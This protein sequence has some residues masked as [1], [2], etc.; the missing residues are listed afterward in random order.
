MS[1]LLITGSRKASEKMILTAFK[2]VHRAQQNG[3]DIIVGDARGIDTHV[4]RECVNLGVIYDCFG[5]TPTP[6][7]P[8]CALTNYHYLEFQGTH[9]ERYLARDRH[10]ADLADYCLAIWDGS[11]GGTIYTYKYFKGLDKPCWLIDFSK[12]E[13]DK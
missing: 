7:C 13:K 4:I 5:I 9:K 12:L 10:M 2:A 6:R 8:N 11:S 1:S 3:W